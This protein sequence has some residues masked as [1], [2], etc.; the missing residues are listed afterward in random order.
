[1][2]AR[3]LLAAAALSALAAPASAQSLLERAARGAGQALAEGAAREATAGL[4]GRRGRSEAS[5]AEAGA[6][7]TAETPAGDA[8]P[9]DPAVVAAFADPAPVN[10]SPSM[11][12]PY[13][14]EFSPELQSAERAFDEFNAVPCDDC[15]GGRSYD[16]WIRHH[17]SEVRPMRA[18]ENR[19]G[20][21]AIGEAIRWTGASGAQLALTV[22]GE[23]PVGAWPCKQVR[24]SSERDGRSAER[25]GLFCYGKRGDYLGDGW[26][27]VL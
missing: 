1:M 19:V 18:L 20:E 12:G 21:M 22:I 16:S 7:R 23:E 10:Y 2:L 15:E 27:E 9:A 5:E 26:V 24:W 13:R 6:P 3:A 14:L 25:L 11:P 17:V 8:A 4:F